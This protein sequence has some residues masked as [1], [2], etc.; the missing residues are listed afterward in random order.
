MGLAW[1]FSWVSS[2]FGDSRRRKG[3]R[4][5]VGPSLATPKSFVVGGL[6]RKVEKMRPKQVHAMACRWPILITSEN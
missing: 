1:W 5:C 2:R 4:C 6:A 3:G